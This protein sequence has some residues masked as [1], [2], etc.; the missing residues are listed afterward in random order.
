M[1]TVVALTTAVAVARL[2]VELIGGLTRHQRHDSELAADDVDLCHHLVA[3]DRDDD[4]L[5]V[6]AGA[7]A[8]RRTP[9]AQ[10]VGEVG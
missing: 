7:R 5:Q 10:Q 1:I 9:L 4:P 3:L 8:S 6:V 2:E